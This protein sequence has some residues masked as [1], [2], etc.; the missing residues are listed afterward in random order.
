MN[1][2]V[3][4][5]TAVAL[6]ISAPTQAEVRING[7]ANLVGGIATGFDPVD[8]TSTVYGYDDTISF[9]SESLFAIQ[10]SGDI[11]D[12]MTATGQLVSRGAD[13][14]DVDFE[15]AYLTFE[16]TDNLSISAGRLRLPLF[17]YSASSDIGYSYHW[18]NA[19]RSVYDVAFTNIEGIRF[20]YSDYAGDWEYTLQAVVG[21]YENDLAGGRLIGDNT[22]LGS[23]E[24]TYESLKFRAVYGANKATYT[25]ADLEGAVAGLRQLGAASLAADLELVDDTGTFLGLGFEYDNFDYFFSAEYTVVEN[26]ESYSPKDVAYYATVGLRSGKWTPSVTYEVKDGNDDLKFLD[27]V[28]ALPAAVQPTATAIVA[29]T[30]LSIME[31]VSIVTLGVRY[32][33]DT[34][35]AFKADVSSYR[36]DI[37]DSNDATL[38]RVAVNY[39]F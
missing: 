33:Y 12:R 21:N 36:D 14:Y 5:M 26:E 1:K 13:D 18:V 35:V 31:D 6:A 29:G 37:D 34:N 15:W 39:V 9:S 32:D 11:N 19:P 38:I 25:R 27:Q 30:Q 10:I 8:P 22:Y 3:F 20:D 23:A 28:A 7:F 4:A 16:A 24:F 17:R 2:T